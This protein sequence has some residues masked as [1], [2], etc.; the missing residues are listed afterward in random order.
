[1]MRLVV[2]YAVA[3]IIAAACATPPAHLYYTGI[4]GKSAIQMDLD[5]AK[6][7]AD[8]EPDFNKGEVYGHFQYDDGA[9][10]YLAGTVHAGQLVLH[11]QVWYYDG[12]PPLSTFTG[13]LS[14]DRKTVTGSW[15]G[16]KGTVKQ[17]VAL[18]AVAE[19]RNV[20][21]PRRRMIIRAG[22]YPVFYH[23]TRAM[24][25]LT[26]SCREQVYA[27][28]DEFMV[29]NRDGHEG[30]FDFDFY[31]DYTFDLAYYSPK[32]V[33]L[34]VNE[35]TYTGGAHGDMDAEGQTYLLTPDGPQQLGLH[36]FFNQDSR[37]MDAL[38]DLVLADLERQRNTPRQKDL[39][40]LPDDAMSPEN[41]NVYTISRSGITFIFPPG[42]LDFYAAGTLSSTLTF[43][44]FKDYLV[45][46][47]VTQLLQLGQVTLPVLV[48][49]DDTDAI[50]LHIQAAWNAVSLPKPQRDI[51][52]QA[53]S[54]MRKISAAREGLRQ[55]QLFET[56]WVRT[57]FLI[58]DLEHG[59]T[60]AAIV[61]TLH[62]PVAEPAARQRAQASLAVVDAQAKTM[63]IPRKK[64]QDPAEY[65]NN[66]QALLYAVA[67]LYLA[68]SSWPDK[69]AELACGYAEKVTAP[70]P[71]PVEEK[72]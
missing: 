19:Y 23:P 18:A 60:L 25:A 39:G 70:I 38:M 64:P 57:G 45:H 54:I 13:C 61:Q 56:V 17:A 26:A 59:K 30:G 65:T 63:I 62:A 43:S 50:G 48:A 12:Q 42:A 46:N 49:G 16:A 40:S 24:Q 10:H 41:M 22:S 6:R 32:L 66:A 3:C 31:D 2:V 52:L 47:N 44:A 28:L 33:S 14:A 15:S 72:K 37:Y 21:L 68:S 20:R 58:N 36:D 67:D 1:M 9:W 5:F 27:A 29:E 35:S 71:E 4:L 7:G 69:V 55:A 11:E 34:R 51:Y 53:N 8:L